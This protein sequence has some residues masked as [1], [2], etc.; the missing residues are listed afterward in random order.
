MTGA[1]LAIGNE[2]VEGRI[3]NRTSF[4]AARL[5][6]FKGYEIKEINTIP[7]EPSIIEFYVKDFLKR[8]DFIVV[9]GGLGPTTDDL[10]NASVAKALGRK[11]IRSKEM[12]KRIR[13][14]EKAYGLPENPLRLKMADLPEGAELLTD[15]H[16]MAGYF[17]KVDE[18]LIFCLPGVPEE[19]EFLFKEKVLPLLEKYLPAKEVFLFK[20]FK[21]FGLHEAEINLALEKFETAWKDVTVGYYPSTPEIHIALR[22]KSHDKIL[23]EKFLNKVSTTIKELF[24]PYIFGEDEELLEGVVGK[25]LL[26]R[27]ETLALAES[28]TGGLVA[29]RITRI[30]GAS[31]YFERGVVSYSNEAKIEIL[32]V[33]KEA[34]E[35]HGAV[36]EPVAKAM[37]E[38][39]KKLA[40]STYGI[41]ITGIAGPTGGSLEKPVGTVWIGFSYPEGTV[42]QCFRFPGDRQT[43]QDYA[44]TT[45]L[46]WLRRFLSYGTLIPSYQ[47]TCKN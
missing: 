13:E 10:T 35:T 45:A 19:F 43:V 14:R 34:V 29:S 39:I 28:C 44:A 30:P 18:K 6:L 46:D 20:L 40:K 23:A 38:G 31:A 8:Y 24:G 15:D 25:L 33:P 11:L 32:G 42:A 1:I 21:L 5:L 9:S 26:S 37:A 7:D 12:E 3:L 27:K 2:L 16:P 41:G 4:W 36:S 17:L 47:F 22:I